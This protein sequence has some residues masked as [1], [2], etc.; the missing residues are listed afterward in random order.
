MPEH[1]NGL[2]GMVL[3]ILPKL[4]GTRRSH[5]GRVATM[6]A[7]HTLRLRTS[8]TRKVRSV[9]RAL[10]CPLKAHR[11]GVQMEIFGM[12]KMNLIMGEGM[13]MLLVR[14]VEDQVE[15]GI[16][17]PTLTM[18]RS[19]AADQRNRRRRKTKRI[20]GQGQKMLILFRK[21]SQGRRKNER[22]VNLG[23]KMLIP[24]L[25]IAKSFLRTLKVGSIVQ[26]QWEAAEGNQMC[27]ETA[28]R[29]HRMKMICSLTSSDA[30]CSDFPV[31]S[32]SLTRC[33]PGGIPHG[34]TLSHCI[35]FPGYISPCNISHIETYV[36]YEV[37]FYRVLPKF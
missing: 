28:R 29:L 22:R 32:S 6:I 30:F 12:K 27:R 11:Q 37:S 3:S 9:A 8:L 13:G 35:I 2:S 1:L 33:H 4:N 36:V 15:G 7:Y 26:E 21:R 14:T 18:L 19:R 31:I 25:A 20:D 23:G 17:L 24:I 10:S 16:T 5:S 34:L